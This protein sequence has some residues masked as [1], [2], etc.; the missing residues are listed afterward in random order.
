[1]EIDEELIG[2]LR[3]RINGLVKEARVPGTVE[4]SSV[5]FFKDDLYFEFGEEFQRRVVILMSAGCS[6]PTCTMC[7][8]T[9]YNNFGSE[10]S[11]LSPLAQL[12]EHTAKH[13]L[14]QT[15]L[16]AIYNDGSFFADKEISREHRIEVAR[17]IKSKEIERVVVESLPQFVTDDSLCEFVSAIYP[18]KLTIGV[19]LQSAN[20]VVRELCVNTKFS[21]KE[22][23]R[24]IF[25]CHQNGVRVKSYVMLKPPFLTDDESLA[26]VEETALYLKSIDSK[27]MTLCPTRVADN[28][29]VA[30]LAVRGLF[31]PPKIETL[32]AA[33][34]VVSSYVDC[35]VAVQNL[36]GD[37][38]VAEMT[39][40]DDPKR[41]KRL[42]ASL[43]DVSRKA[44]PVRFDLLERDRVLIDQAKKNS[45]PFDTAKLLERIAGYTA[46]LEVA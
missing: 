14:K 41:M 46:E 37:D 45:C 19:G 31:C 16:I 28:T 17:W 36:I 7:P 20:N 1:M 39:G 38:F 13:P 27:H 21:L 2:K 18:K 40:E 25:L 8:F 6:V 10:V 5:R 43:A 11:I 9:N 30:K 42:L 26:D 44:G 35:R 12:E 15:N 24:C 22:F 23:E 3:R 34:E 32:A 33:V 4:G 29:L